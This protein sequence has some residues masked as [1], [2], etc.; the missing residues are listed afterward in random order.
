MKIE[1]SLKGIPLF[2]NLRS[3][4]LALVV[5]ST[6]LVTYSAG[7]T[8]IR[9]GRAGTAFFMIVSG[10]V[11]VVKDMDGPSPVVLA[12]FGP[13]DFF[14][15]IASIRQL[16]RSAS[17]RAL[18]ETECLVIWR[19]D[20]EAFISQFPEAAAQLEAKAQARLTSSQGHLEG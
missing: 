13:G 5:R 9:E 4:E 12:N 1:E 10:R 14:G 8:I 19:A 20:F 11:E 7:R 15:E 6:R 18:Q 2:Q 17:V 16:P 3:D